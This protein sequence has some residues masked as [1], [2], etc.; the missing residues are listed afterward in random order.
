LLT[1][2]EEIETMDNEVGCPVRNPFFL[3][4]PEELRRQLAAEAKA[5][6]RSLNAEIVYRLRQ[7]LK[8]TADRVTA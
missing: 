4:F 2:I 3:R 1:A 5:A 6:E 7:S 8:I